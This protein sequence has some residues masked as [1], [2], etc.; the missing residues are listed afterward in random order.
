[1]W[2]EYPA[3]PCAVGF[4]VNDVKGC[5]STSNQWSLHNIEELLE[6]AKK[7][8]ELSYGCE[9]LEV[10]IKAGAPTHAARGAICGTVKVKLEPPR[11]SRSDR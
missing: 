9:S 11:H 6:A 7:G 8:I 5:R 2:L 4:V 1:V 3:T 10:K